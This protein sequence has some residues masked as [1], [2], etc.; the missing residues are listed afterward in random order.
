MPA[1]IKFYHQNRS[2][3]EFSNFYVRP[4]TVDNVVWPIGTEQYFQA[5][6]SED[7]EVQEYVRIKLT[8]PGQIKTYCTQQVK[9]RPN[10][11]DSVDVTPPMADIF[12]DDRGLVVDRV[13]DYFMY[14]ALVCKFSQHPDLAKVLLD[15]GDALLVED[16][17][18]V[19]S[20]PYWG[21]GP[22]DTG[23]N[24]LGRMLM[25]IRKALPRHIT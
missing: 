10:W 18:S 6:K 4:I 2:Y 8:R 3:G 22:S 24:K 19:G 21:N 17:Q 16:T 12:R 1:M 14:Q 13:K 7:P 11:E 20:D 5:M 23:L 9:L 15:T 25:I